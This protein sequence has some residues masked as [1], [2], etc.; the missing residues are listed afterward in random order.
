MS[1]GV[2]APNGLDFFFY[3]LLGGTLG[4]SPSSCIGLTGVGY[5]DEIY[6]VVLSFLAYA[7][8]LF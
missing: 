5:C 2:A 3:A 7:E 8:F 4:I 6:I 1:T